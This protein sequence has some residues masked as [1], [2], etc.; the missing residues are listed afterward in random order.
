MNLLVGATGMVGTEICRLLA[1]A[2]KPVRALVR[3]TSDPAKIDKLKA[4]GA[5][6]VEGDLRDPES[7]RIACQGVTTV[8][9][10]ASAMPFAYDASHNTLRTTD[11]DGY[12]HLVRMAREAGVQQFVYTSFPPLAASF[13]LQDA[14]RAVEKELR[15]SGLVYTILQP[16]YFMEIW[17]SPAVGFDY[18]NCKAV[19]YGAGDNAISWISFLDVAQFA[20][21]SV[22][23]PRAR[24]ATFELGGPHGISPLNMVA[25]FERVGGKSFEV[26]HV[27]V[28]ALQVQL[29][30]AT[31]A[32]QKSYAGL[33]LGY[34][35]HASIDM[36]ATLKTFP[37]TL[38]TVQDY[39]RSVLPS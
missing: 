3:A 10:T 32:M 25:I 33:M 5:S 26:T 13:P 16:T 11:Q 27:P 21:A 6:V 31:D 24:N 37:L 7:L 23:N 12:I 9:T 20:A 35:S 22:G 17:L 30:G 14:K 1:S 38:R 15:A 19:V 36:T 8:V 28:E 2:G 29:A 34:A 39:A 4:L 18:P